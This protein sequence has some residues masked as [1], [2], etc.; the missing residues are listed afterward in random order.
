MWS[1]TSASSPTPRHYERVRSSPHLSTRSG[2]RFPI[3]FNR[4][5]LVSTR[6][7]TIF[8]I[9]I[10]RYILLLTI[11]L[12]FHETVYMSIR[13]PSS[14]PSSSYI[15]P[16][17]PFADPLCYLDELKFLTGMVLWMDR[18]RHR[19][20]CSN[21]VV[22]S[23]VDLRLWPLRRHDTT[24]S[25]HSH[26]PNCTFTSDVTNPRSCG[27]EWITYA[28]SCSLGLNRLASN[29]VNSQ[30]PLTTL[31]MGQ[32]WRGWGQRLRSYH[33]YLTTLP[34]HRL[35]ILT[36]AEDVI[37]SPVGCDGDDV[38]R[39]FLKRDSVLS[40]I[41]A[42]AETACWP[43]QSMKRFY[44][45]ERLVSRPEGVRDP[46]VQGGFGRKVVESRDVTNDN[47]VETSSSS[48]SSTTTRTTTTPPSEFKYLNAGTI[49]GL[50]VDV[51]RWLKSLY[52]NDCMDDQ[53]SFTS[54]YL[55]PDMFYINEA[56]D[57]VTEIES[58]MTTRSKIEQEKGRNSK[59]YKEVEARYIEAATRYM[60]ISSD[61]RILKRG[62]EVGSGS[63]Q[64]LPPHARPEVSLDHDNEMFV[65]MYGVELKDFENGADVSG[66]EEVVFKATGGSPCL[67]HQSGR[68][69][70]NRVLEELAR[71]FKMPYSQS[72]IDKAERL[73][74]GA[75]W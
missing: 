54:S 73:K 25:T 72:A 67:L 36:D 12:A 44:D 23:L 68:K 65:S 13:D 19:Q 35:V 15:T 46:R 9:R 3:P 28:T 27:I 75:W 40:P 64:A 55:R 41:W 16:Q 6:S 29:I 34:D 24:H 69:V 43:D 53:G 8:T 59:A 62:P 33:D 21:I 51:R 38:V 49:I 61:K 47:N 7:I 32:G 26:P 31:G 42:A 11:L 17:S 70:E 30:I 1:S 50:A 37:V 18:I 22:E 20:E 56:Q 4:S 5:L 57:L 45:D 66:G 10:F 14:P 58:L 39:R 52:I 71:V 74:K 2:I 48:G 60:A 63:S